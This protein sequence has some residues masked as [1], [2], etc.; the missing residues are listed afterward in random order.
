MTDAPDID[1]PRV[2]SL[3]LDTLGAPGGGPWFAAYSGG[4]D[5]TVLLHL[6]ARI[7]RE[8]GIRLI[9][10]HADHGLHRVSGD[11]RRHC[12]ARCSEWGVELRSA[13]L[14]V[15]DEEGL[16]P[17]G[18]ARAARYQWFRQAA[19]EDAWLFTA[20]HRGDQAETVIERL[21]RGAG[22]RGMR[23]ILPVAQ[24]HDMWL[25]RPLLDHPR[26]AIR[27]YAERHHLAWVS[28]HSNLD[29]Y[30]SR[31]YIRSRVL[32][33]LTERWPAVENS[34][35]QSAKVMADTQRILDEE[36]V[37]DLQRMR[38]RRVRGDPCLE[39]AALRDVSPERRRNALRHWIAEETGVSLGYSRIARIERA[40]EQW[41]E[42][43]GGLNWP[44]VEL[45]LYRD[46]L[47]LLR[48]FD[49]PAGVESWDLESSLRLSPG[50][51]LRPR[52]VTGRGLRKAALEGGVGVAFRRGGEKCR[53]P[54]RAHHHSLKNI[55]QEA[56][57][58]PW[59]R[60]RMPLILV[61]NAVAAIPGVACCEPWIVGP[62][63][64]GIEIE[65]VYH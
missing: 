56:G 25:L 57:V 20:H 27:A 40:I 29:T 44:P 6:L 36:A 30:F 3:I 54:G 60:P 22:P 24:L 17:E 61:E 51:V 21:T 14:N 58:P 31:N 10:L 43:I 18:A 5:S 1:V 59:Q 38:E 2:K 65:A 46:D 11:W 41:P 64:T 53:L 62:G 13:E 50:L 48:A 33:A 34:L 16:G 26:D 37:S 55:L 28:D 32:P 8:E 49:T 42:D 39:I 12:R 47:Y 63:E 45:R 4:L 15:V 35:G 9:A 23:G 52:E 19:G 7:C